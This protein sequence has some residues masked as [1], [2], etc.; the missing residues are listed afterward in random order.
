MRKPWTEQD[1]QKL[2]TLYGALPAAQIAQ[3]MGRTTSSVQTCAK[4]LGLSGTLNMPWTDEDLALLRAQYPTENLSDLARRM[5]REVDHL[6]R[7]ASSLGVSRS[8]QAWSKQAQA[9][10]PGSLN[11]SCRQV[12]KTVGANGATSAVAR[13]ML[14]EPSS[15]RVQQA[16]RKLVE[17]GHAWSANPSGRKGERRWF[18]REDWARAFS[19]DL[20]DH[21][22]MARRR[23]DFHHAKAK[24]RR[25]DRDF[26]A[27]PARET[28]RTKRHIDLPKPDHRFIATEAPALFSAAR[29]GQY[30]EPASSWVNAVCRTAA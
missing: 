22:V 14:G 9:R 30:L 19:G 5:G 10:W 6:R 21:A 27:L 26:A 23:E 28:E 24:A 15:A 18:E 16:L 25:A 17:M 3:Q 29:P 13:G 20:D 12:L 1:R 11:D 7:K 8:K 4:H 2:R